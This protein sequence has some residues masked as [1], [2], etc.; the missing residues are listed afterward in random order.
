MCLVLGSIQPVLHLWI[1]FAP[2][3]GTVPTGLHI[4]DSAI[5]IQSMDIFESGCYSP[6]ATAKSEH[7]ARYVGHYPMPYLWGY[8][9]LGVVASTL[10]LDGFLVYGFANGIGVAC[11][12][13]VVYRFLRTIVPRIADRAFLLFALSGGPGGLLFLASA[14]TGLTSA[15]QFDEYFFRF[16]LYELIEGAH[17]LPVTYFP[18]L[19]YVVSMALCL[20]GFTAFL[21]A[22]KTGSVRQIVSAGSLLMAGAFV[23]G[24]FGVFTLAI[25]FLY[26]S[27]RR[28]PLRER[29][30]GVPVFGGL[31]IA[32]WACGWKLMQTSPVV[33][34]NHVE[35]GNMAMWLSPFV[36]AALVHL[37]IFPRE[38]VRR[39]GELTPAG[40]VAA[41]AGMGYL[42]AFAGLF[43]LYQVYYGNVL[44]ARDGSVAARISDAALLGAAAGLIYALVRRGKPGG[45]GPAAEGEAD[46]WIVL[47]L[48]AFLALSVS[49]F[50]R[51]WFL[52]FGPQRLML[53]LWL[54]ICIL[55][56]HGLE[57]MSA[58]G[59]ERRARLW[60]GALVVCGVVSIAVSSFWF[61]GPMGRAQGRGPYA[62]THTEVMTTA[63]AALI[64]AIG[65]GRVMA[66]APASDVAVRQRGNP[67]FFGVGSFNLA[68]RRYLFLKGRTDWF[69]SDGPTDDERRAFVEE[70]AIDAVYCPDTWPVDEAVVKILRETPWLEEVASQGAGAVFTVGAF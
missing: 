9:L 68:E 42:A 63:D 50:V 22:R 19:Y 47:W 8:G 40:R 15:P 31:G 38:V 11:F 5:F 2:P 65:E 14:L 25:A 57:R 4:P 33:I 7:G 60:T 1:A 16:A 52:R 12:L 67:V 23:N 24:R 51:G 43:C 41:Y 18:R 55:S 20:G 44:I 61:Q 26:L 29:F 70:W 45:E 66:P 10:G 28:E 59:R 46:A 69:F 34:Q 6:Y 39:A 17:L 30:R 56:A 35:V 27:Q 3:E 36:A 48:L 32:G 58:T 53:F 21:S 54:P 13:L 37:F 62:W 64:A 49:G